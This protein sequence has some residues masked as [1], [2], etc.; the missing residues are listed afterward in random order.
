MSPTCICTGLSGNT[1]SLETVRLE[2]YPGEENTDEQQEYGDQTVDIWA[3]RLLVFIESS[4]RRAYTIFAGPPQTVRPTGGRAAHPTVHGCYTLDAPEAVVAGD[5]DD[6]IVPTGAFLKREGSSITATY[7]DKRGRRKVVHLDRSPWFRR[8]LQERSLDHHRTQEEEKPIYIGELI[9]QYADCWEGDPRFADEPEHIA[10]P[11][12]AHN[13]FGPWSFRMM[14]VRDGWSQ[15]HL[16]TTA[17]SFGEYLRMRRDRNW[18]KQPAWSS[19]GMSHGCVHIEWPHLKELIAAGWARKGR[20][21][22]VHPYGRRGPRVADEPG[23]VT[24]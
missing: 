9:T 12:Y 8:R 2:V 15:Q 18:R 1:C 7:M 4:P 14:R 17:Y 6:A 19:L 20:V 24:R 21:M 3:G 22:I 11:K 5:W 23:A 10:T 13:P 16:H